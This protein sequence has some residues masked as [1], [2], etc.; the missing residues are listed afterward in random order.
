MPVDPLACQRT[1]GA[2]NDRVRVRDGFSILSSSSRA[3]LI[4]VDLAGP[5]APAL[6]RRQRL[7]RSGWY[8]PVESQVDGASLT[9]GVP[10][11]VVGHDWGA[12][13]PLHQKPSY[14]AHRCLELASVAVMGERVAPSVRIGPVVRDLRA[15]PRHVSLIVFGGS[16][17]H[18]AAC[19][20]A[21]R[22]RHGAPD[23]GCRRA[24]SWLRPVVGASERIT[25]GSADERALDLAEIHYLNVTLSGRLPGLLWTVSSARMLLVEIGNRRQ[26]YSAHLVRPHASVILPKISEERSV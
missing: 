25:T 7:W 16:E 2:S 20:G 23:V 11:A 14:G 22:D 1:R 24:V 21:G 26:E 5:P 15:H 12:G 4:F 8:R 17:A 10:A 6:A 13:R 18:L 9:L 3:K 19:C